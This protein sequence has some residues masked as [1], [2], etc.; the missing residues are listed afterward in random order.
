MGCN[1]VLGRTLERSPLSYICSTPNVGIVGNFPQPLLKLVNTFFEFAN[2]LSL[3][4]YFIQKHRIGTLPYICPIYGFCSIPVNTQF[5]SMLGNVASIFVSL[6]DPMALLGPILLMLP[7]PRPHRSSNPL[8]ESPSNSAIEI[9]R[10]LIVAMSYYI[11]LRIM[12]LFLTELFCVSKISVIFAACYCF[13]S[14]QRYKK[15]VKWARKHGVI[16]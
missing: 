11:I 12:T 2:F 15:G 14:L 9:S 7:R 8:I 1:E 13:N 16:T 10:S 6:S 4:N 5:M 3:F